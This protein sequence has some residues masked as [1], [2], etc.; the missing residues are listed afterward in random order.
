MIHFAMVSIVRR[1]QLERTC[2]AQARDRH[3]RQWFRHRDGQGIDA[4]PHHDVGAIFAYKLDELTT[5]LV[6]CDIV[7][8][9]AD[10]EQIRTVREDLPGFDIAMRASRACPAS[11]GSGGTQ[12][13][14]HPSP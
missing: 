6:C 2:H 5:E 8:D 1:L 3:H 4:V 13:Y 12:S 7:T 10:G 14:S 11:I 9:A